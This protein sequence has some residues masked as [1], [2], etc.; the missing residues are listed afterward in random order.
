MERSLQIF[1]MIIGNVEVTVDDDLYLIWRGEFNIGLA[2]QA[3]TTIEDLL[4]LHGGRVRRD[5]PVL[6]ENGWQ[7]YSSTYH[8]THL[9]RN[10]IHQFTL[11]RNKKREPTPEPSQAK[12]SG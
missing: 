11:T 1:R 3:L 6:T 8:A 10:H 12:S 5:K 7:E 9:L 4:C 2:V